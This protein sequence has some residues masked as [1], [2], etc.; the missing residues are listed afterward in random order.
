[1]SAIFETLSVLLFHTGGQLREKMMEALQQAASR[2]A[3]PQVQAVFDRLKTPEGM[4][5]VLMLFLIA[6]FVVSIAAGSLAGALTGAFLG[7]RNRL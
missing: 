6:L 4:A 2:T 5:A 1:M 3:D 7:R